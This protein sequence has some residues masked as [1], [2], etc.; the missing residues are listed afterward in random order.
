MAEPAERAGQLALV[1]ILAAAPAVALAEPPPAGAILAA[2]AIPPAVAFLEAEA[3]LPRGA[4]RVQA[5]LAAEDRAVMVAAL[6][7][8]RRRAVRP[9]AVALAQLAARLA[10]AKAFHYSC[11][12]PLG[13]FFDVAGRRAASGWTLAR[14]KTP[15]A[16]SC[17]YVLSD[18]GCRHFRN[19]R[20]SH[21]GSVRCSQ[22]SLRR[23]HARMAATSG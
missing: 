14:L 6:A 2:A 7:A 22:H 16:S 17:E 8:H 21:Y 10:R 4:T 19:V 3:A 5:A 12:R 1:A 15:F 13:W 23:Y 20:S 18:G 9:L 11:L